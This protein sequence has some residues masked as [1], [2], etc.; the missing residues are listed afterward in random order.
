MLRVLMRPR[1]HGAGGPLASTFS[2]PTFDPPVPTIDFI[3]DFIGWNVY[4][5]L[6]TSATVSRSADQEGES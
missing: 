4:L 3:V 5:D 2:R 6:M 1:L